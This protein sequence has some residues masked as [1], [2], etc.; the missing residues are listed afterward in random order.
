MNVNSI[1]CTVNQR[2]V[3]KCVECALSGDLKDEKCYTVELQFIKTL[4]YERFRI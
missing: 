4:L 1:K 3:A 2:N